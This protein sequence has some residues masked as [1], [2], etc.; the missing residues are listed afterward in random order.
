M[1]LGTPPRT[2]LVLSSDSRRGAELEGAA[3]A[4]E[5]TAL[6]TQ[7]QAV[8]LAPGQDG[9]ATGA[10]VLGEKPLSFSTLR[11]LRRLAKQSDM[12]VGYGSKSLPACAIALVGLKTPFVYRSIGNPQD[13]VRGR[14]HRWRTALL[15]RRAAHIVA[16][17]PEAATAIQRIYGIKPE[18]TSALPNARAAQDFLPADN[19]EQEAA[20]GALGIAPDARVVLFL[21]SL[22]DEKRPEVIPAIAAELPDNVFL[23]VGSGPLDKAIRDSARHSVGDVRVLG[24]T[25]VARAM[26]ACADLM[27]SPSRTE[28]MPGSLL[29]AA[30]MG[31]PAVATDVGG[32]G[33]VVG[34]GGLLL[35]AEALPS[36]YATALD[37]AFKDRTILGEKARK[38]ALQRFTSTDVAQQWA[39][40]LASVQ[41]SPT[42]RGRARPAS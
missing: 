42:G 9:P 15:F 4:D 14:L 10:A 19:D 3:L 41:V 39:N 17:W 35:P 23:I 6:G 38:H 28:G 36:E 7:S 29:E 34:D 12:V 33:E 27:V 1:T 30:M 2:L 31:V 16:L 21:G 32:V 20:R 24:P 37:A 40:L 18:N 5:L 13:W 26:I 11:A 8:A 22:S 25:N